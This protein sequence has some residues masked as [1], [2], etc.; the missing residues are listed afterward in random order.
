MEEVVMDVF[1]S[2]QSKGQVTWTARS[3]I[4]CTSNTNRMLLMKGNAM[5][6]SRDSG[7]LAVTT[8][9]SPTSHN[10]SN[11]KPGNRRDDDQ[12][13]LHLRFQDVEPHMSQRIFGVRM[14]PGV[15]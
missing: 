10:N 2:L 7:R 6:S 13:M 12:S 11:A 14:T 9:R 1:A 4:I 8:Q 15:R 3:G 5:Q